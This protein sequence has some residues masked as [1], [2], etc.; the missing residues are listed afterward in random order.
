M[1]GDEIPFR[2]GGAVHR[3]DGGRIPG[4]LTEANKATH[5]E[6]G[7]VDV[8]PRAK[9]KCWKCT[10][11]IPPDQGGPGCRK[12]KGPIEPVGWCRRFVLWTN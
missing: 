1:G 3:A 6:V 9:Q 4:E 12:V 7:Y 2:Q 8:S 5:A 11:Y 10:K